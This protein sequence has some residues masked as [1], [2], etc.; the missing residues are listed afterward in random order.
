MVEENDSTWRKGAIF[1][2]TRIK[3][4]VAY[5]FTNRSVKRVVK[6]LTRKEVL[7]VAPNVNF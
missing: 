2:D 4:M 5:L 7:N 6:E 1:R 3:E